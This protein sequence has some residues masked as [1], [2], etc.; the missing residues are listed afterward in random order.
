MGNIAP[1]PTGFETQQSKDFYWYDAV[2]VQMSAFGF[3]N[4]ID[5]VT[6]TDTAA[7]IT[8]SAV[9]SCLASCASTNA[10][11]CTSTDP[12]TN[13]CVPVTFNKNA[14]LFETQEH[15]TKSCYSFAA[16]AINNSNTDYANTGY[17]SNTLPSYG[18][19]GYGTCS[20]AP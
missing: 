12:N 10:P 13:S 17:T 6:P 3:N 15:C 9:I 8:T 2:G 18:V 7:E 14:R 1:C 19:D 4:V 20:K 11:L 5:G 16:L